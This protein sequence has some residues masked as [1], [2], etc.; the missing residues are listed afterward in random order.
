MGTTLVYAFR[1]CIMNEK[2]KKEFLIGFYVA[3][4]AFGLI[5]AVLLI[6]LCI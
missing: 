1:G 3:L 2:M 4:A 5:A 6:I